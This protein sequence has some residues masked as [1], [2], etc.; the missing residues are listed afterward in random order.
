MLYYCEHTASHIDYSKNPIL[1]YSISSAFILCLGIPG[2]PVIGFRVTFN[3]T[4]T[5]ILQSALS[6]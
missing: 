1:S 3:P 6:F 4:V 5:V 2:F